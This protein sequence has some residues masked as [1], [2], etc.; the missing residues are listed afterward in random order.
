LHIVDRK[1]ADNPV[2]DNFSRMENM[3]VEPIHINVSFPDEKLAVV[4]VSSHD[5]PWFADYAKY[6]VAKYIPPKFTY[7]QKKK[8]FYDLRHSFW[9]DP[10]LYK[11]E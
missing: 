3:L 4:N 7:Q 2:V 5:N 6:I 9:D 10:H 11:K 1:G 8:F